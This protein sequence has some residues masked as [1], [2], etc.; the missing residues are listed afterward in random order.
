VK[1]CN[2][3]GS[4]LPQG[5]VD[6]AR[7]IGGYRRLTQGQDAPHQLGRGHPGVEPKSRTG[8]IA[9]HRCLEHQ[10]TPAVDV[11]DIA[12]LLVEVVTG[13]P[14][15]VICSMFWSTLTER[16]PMGTIM[17]SWP[18]LPYPFVGPL[19]TAKTN[20]MSAPKNTLA[21]PL[22]SGAPALDRLGVTTPGALEGTVA[23]PRV[24]TPPTSRAKAT[25]LSNPISQFHLLSGELSYDLNRL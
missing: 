2:E 15:S 14:P 12:S 24:M 1:W 5:G 10:G 19:P 7:C 18:V 9:L 11:E 17:V 13:Q 20:C 23:P 8:A 16:A 25:P 4:W 21:L 22:G 6:H 3:T